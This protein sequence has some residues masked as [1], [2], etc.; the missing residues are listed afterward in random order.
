[1]QYQIKLVHTKRKEPLKFHVPKGLLAFQITCIEEILFQGEICEAINSLR[2]LVSYFIPVI[3]GK[4]SR[5]ERLQL[6]DL[7]HKDIKVKSS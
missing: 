5:N 3:N 4:H 2:W 1:M 7:Y 6:L